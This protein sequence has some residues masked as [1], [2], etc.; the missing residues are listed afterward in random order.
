MLVIQISD[1]YTIFQQAENPCS[2]GHFMWDLWF[3][4]LNLNIYE[5]N[6]KKILMHDQDP[7]CRHF[8]IFAKKSNAAMLQ[9]LM[10]CGN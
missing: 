6:N 8:G 5:F 3:K 2:C 7:K 1:F 10:V 4:R 9:Q